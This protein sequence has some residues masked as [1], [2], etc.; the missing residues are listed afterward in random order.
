MGSGQSFKNL[1]E[2]LA[3]TKRVT[4][5]SLPGL[6]LLQTR[7]TQFSNFRSKPVP[8][9]SFFT[10]FNATY[11]EALENSLLSD[12]TFYFIFAGGIPAEKKFQTKSLFHLLIS[13]VGI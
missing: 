8:F 11:L 4:Y 3:N 13:F 10:N 6:Y 7:E 9:G 5:F 2:L 12:T 1:K